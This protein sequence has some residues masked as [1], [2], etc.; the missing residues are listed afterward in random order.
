[1]QKKTDKLAL[2]AESEFHRTLFWYNLCCNSLLGVTTEQAAGVTSKYEDDRNIS[3]LI[4]RNFK[5]PSLFIPLELLKPY[6]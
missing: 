1:M 5:N 3:D 6:I 4:K 2:L